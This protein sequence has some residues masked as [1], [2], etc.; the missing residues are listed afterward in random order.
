MTRR[1]VWICV[2]ALC[3]T[4]C[5]ARQ[6]NITNLPAGVTLAEVQHW[7]SAVANLDKIAQT[8]ST[9][10]KAVVS[11]NQQ[12]VISD[13]EYYGKF[14]T[15]LGKIDQLQIDAVQFLKSQPKNWGVSTQ[16]KV[17]NDL[18]LMQQELLN[19]TQQQLAG[20]KSA[21]AQKQVGALVT[22]I[23][24]LAAIVLSTVS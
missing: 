20:I 7:D 5:A 11:L 21:G 1:I 8:T 13:G 12:G 2:V 10:R 4:G 15:A 16:L 24:D 19:I 9:L 3:M 14:L 6:K 23:G 17:K 22:E 18:A